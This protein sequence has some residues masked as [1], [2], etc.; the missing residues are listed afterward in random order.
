MDIYLTPLKNTR[1]S[2]EKQ[3]NGSNRL[4]RNRMDIKIKHQKRTNMRRWSLT[5]LF[6]APSY[7]LP[8][9]RRITAQLP[10]PPPQPPPPP[11]QLPPP[12]PQPPPPPPHPPA[13]PPPAQPPDMEP[14]DCI[15]VSHR[16]NSR[17]KYADCTRVITYTA[18]AGTTTGTGSHAARPA[19]AAGTVGPLAG[20]H[21]NEAGAGIVVARVEVQR[22]HVR[23]V[24]CSVSFSF[25]LFFSFSLLHFHPL[26][27]L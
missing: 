15:V 2:R 16:I 23:R 5:S 14:Q 24:H 3:I 11:P 20:A 12:P 8:A 27:L 25:F 7:Q 13:A 26:H 19:A 4:T 21:G 17:Q 6:H 10:P 9:R 18:S 22:V 1:K